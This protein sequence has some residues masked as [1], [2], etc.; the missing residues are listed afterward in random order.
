MHSLG[1]TYNISLW[2]YGTLTPLVAP[3]HVKCSISWHTS[4][5]SRKAQVLKHSSEPRR[6]LTCFCFINSV[7]IHLCV[8]YTC[9]VNAALSSIIQ[10]STVTA[11]LV[12]L[13]LHVLTCGS[14]NNP[15]WLNSAVMTQCR[16]IKNSCWKCTARLY[17]NGCS[18]AGWHNQNAIH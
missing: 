18:S 5:N 6:V 13:L 12:T 16:K 17:V 11:W 14:H 8:Q 3:Q 2:C 15:P 7:L 10:H 1:T 4:G 9:A